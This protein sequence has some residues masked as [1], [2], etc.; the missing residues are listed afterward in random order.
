MPD[1]LDAVA[2][3]MDGVLVS[4]E[5]EW[6]KIFRGLLSEYGLELSEEDQ[7]ELYG[8]SDEK[9]NEVLGR[10]LGISADLMKVRKDA[11][12][13]VHPIDYG[14]IAIPGSRQLIDD[15]HRRGIKVALASS[16]PRYLVDRMIDETGMAGLFDAVITGDHV[17]VA[18]PDPA[19]YLL[20]AS[21][22]GVDPS[23]VVAIDDSRYG[24]ESARSAGMGA[25]QFAGSGQKVL[26]EDSIALCHDFA[27]VACVI[28][29]I[30]TT[31][32]EGVD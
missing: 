24:L 2:I 22:L 28:D 12:C 15:C 19:I 14:A 16:S 20:A 7:H 13:K 31:R 9:E 6:E 23:H 29:A 10:A 18:K 25:I 4:S 27:E 21:T 11:Y 8:C 17:E 30:V 5:V 32:E 3:D 26:S 1:R